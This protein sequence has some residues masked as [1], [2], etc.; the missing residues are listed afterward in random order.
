MIPLGHRIL[1]L[2]I[3]E[4]SSKGG[5]IIPTSGKKNNKGKVILLGT[6]TK[7][8]WIGK[9]AIYHEHS[10]QTINYNGEDHLML[11]CGPNDSEVIAVL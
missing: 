2:P 11:K 1:V 4:T 8:D 6:A 3:Q 9:T 7:E 5:I 10:G